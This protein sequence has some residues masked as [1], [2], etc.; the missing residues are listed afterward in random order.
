MSRDDL[1]VL[2]IFPDEMSAQLVATELRAEGIESQIF[3]DDAGGAIPP[4]QTTQ[5]VRLFVKKEDAER[6]GT[7]LL[8]LEREGREN[9]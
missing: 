9:S 8:A 4:L 3:S 2:K 6:A 1:I 5:G 7:I